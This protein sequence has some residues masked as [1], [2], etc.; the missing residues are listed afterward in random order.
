MMVGN[1][2]GAQNITWKKIPK[3]SV[4]AEIGVWQGRS[5]KMFLQRNLKHLHLVDPWNKDWTDILDKDALNKVLEKY[6]KIVGSN[7]LSD[8]DDFY[9]KVHSDVVKEYGK[10]ENV[11]IHRQKSVEWMQE[12]SGEKLDWIYIDGD[13]SYEGCLADL[14][15]AL[16]IMKPNG[17][18]FADDYKNSKQ[19]VQRAV[20]DF[21]KKHGFKFQA[22]INYQVQIN[23]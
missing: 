2:T 23:L 19:G 14:E 16:T 20:D 17:I 8:W 3:N 18:I 9:D 10:L 15:T 13:H 5:T 11:T 21:V 6:S 4:G 12:Y 7:K 22:F 1:N